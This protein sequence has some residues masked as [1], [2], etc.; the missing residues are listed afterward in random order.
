V[1]GAAVSNLP[2]G[3][4]VVRERDLVVAADVG[5]TGV[6][7][8]D[9]Q[10]AG[11]AAVF[12]RTIEIAIEN[13]RTSMLRLWQR[14]PLLLIQPRVERFGMFSFGHNRELMEEGYRATKGL[15]ADGDD[16]PGPEA[17]GVYPRRRYAVSVDREHCIGCGACLVHGPP[18]LFALDGDGKAVVTAGE[19]EWSPVEV[20]FV[21]QCPTY[22]IGVHPT[23]DE[24][25]RSTA[26]V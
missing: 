16:I 14:P 6:L 15:L 13:R 17:T 21:R 26:G 3:V 5:S 2:V 1:D 22:A 7:K 18:G 9:L 10:H 12:A 8:A 20:D 25:P 24:R 11:F 23:E 19:Q 4:A